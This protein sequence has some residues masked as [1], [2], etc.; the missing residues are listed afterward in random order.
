MPGL[1]MRNSADLFRFAADLGPCRCDEQCQR[2]R[3]STIAAIRAGLG[4]SMVD[5]AVEEQEKEMKRTQVHASCKCREK[6]RDET[7][8]WF[9]YIEFELLIVLPQS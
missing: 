7:L 5:M 3:D 8:M 2:S 1:E 6:V 4:P 9:D